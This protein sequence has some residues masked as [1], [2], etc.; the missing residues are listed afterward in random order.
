MLFPEIDVRLERV[1]FTAET[2]VVVAV[3]CG[4]APGCPS[5]RARTR[6]VHSSHERG[7][8]ERP[9]TGK[10]LQVRLRVRRFFCN[11]SSCRRKTFVEQV[12]GLS[13]CYRRSSLGLKQWLHAVAVELGGRPGDRLCRK[14]SLTAGRSRLLELLQSPPVPE[15]SPRVLGVDEF[16]FRK[17]RTYGTL[18]VDVEAGQV[19]DVP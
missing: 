8:A 1:D 19:V 7:L 11:R 6:R 5:C 9:L 17:G 4:P 15:R 2:L 14:M 10:K 16:A 13:E 12:G 18:L 3:A